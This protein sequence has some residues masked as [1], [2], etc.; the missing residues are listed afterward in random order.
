M[1]LKKLKQIKLQGGNREIMKTK[2][3]KGI[4]LIALVVTIVV[5][6]ILAGVSINAVFSD[7]GIIKKAQ[8][9]QN[10]MNEAQQK[11][12][13]S[14]NALSN[15]LENQ[16][17]GEDEVVEE[18]EQTETAWAGAIATSYASEE[19]NSYIISTAEQL[20]YFAKQVNEG[21]DYSGKTVL[22]NN[23]IDLNKEK[24]TP[25][26]NGKNRIFKGKFDGQNNTIYNLSIEGDYN[27]RGLFG[28]TG[29]GCSIKN[30]TIDNCNIKGAAFLGGVIGYSEETEIENVSIR[31]DIGMLGT[32]YLGGIVGYSNLSRIKYC[33]IANCN[34]NNAFSVGGIVGYSNSSVIETS[35]VYNANFQGCQ[36]YGYIAGYVKGGTTN[37]INNEPSDNTAYGTVEN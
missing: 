12:L 19:G 24:W 14:I 26:G 37:W 21:N 30:L 23:D 17:G 2:N 10:K 28:H 29:E 25:I 20:A 8:N 22:I 13:N 31:G 36:S 35:T 3:E 34:M 18:K 5:L 32:A 27:Y 9:A 15:W 4:T 33:G 7:N 16:T 1:N 11:D 6:L